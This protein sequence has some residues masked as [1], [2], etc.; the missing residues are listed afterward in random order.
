MM[1]FRFVGDRAGLGAI[2]G[3]RQGISGNVALAISADETCERSGWWASIL[4]VRRTRLR[5]TGWRRVNASAKQGVKDVLANRQNR[6]NISCPDLSYR[7]QVPD[8]DLTPQ[9]FDSVAAIRDLIQRKL[10]LV[11]RPDKRT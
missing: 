1:T 3:E 2:R 5:T 11:P 6:S 7:L 4:S 8:E 9:N 10:E